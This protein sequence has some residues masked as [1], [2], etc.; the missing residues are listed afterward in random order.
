[1]TNLVEFS[2]DLTR[3][4]AG[5]VLAAAVATLAWRARSLTVDGAVA[6]AAIGGIVVGA[7][8][9]WLG[10]LLVLFFV[11]SSG[12]SRLRATRQAQRTGD[13]I[14]RRGSRRDAVQV[15]ANGGAATLGAL[16]FALTGAEVWVLGAVCGIAAANADTWSTE[17]G[18]WAGRTP[19]LI[20]TGRV[21]AP[22][23]SGGVTVPGTSAAIAGAGLIALG[24]AVGIAAG[25][26]ALPFGL[27]PALL[28]VTVAGFAGALIDSVFGATVQRVYRCPLCNLETEQPRHRCGTPTVPVR[29]LPGVTNDTVN[30][31]ATLLAAGLG[32]VMGML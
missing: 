10:T 30:A 32:A 18:R 19:R 16:L 11:T 22:G 5:L 1:M 6:A 14:I 8:G 27:G 25:W 13:A 31:L 15:L 17:I 28:T 21:V 2:G 9:W 26:L 20:T 24:S 4:G 12:L 7:G 23:T 29:G 3:W